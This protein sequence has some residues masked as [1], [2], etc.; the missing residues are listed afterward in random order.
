[1]T[2]S[3]DVCNAIANVV[4]NLWPDRMIYRDFCPVD[5]HRP[6]SYLYLTSSQMTP[7]NISMVQWEME[8]S[9]ELFCSTDEYDISSTEELRK[10]QEAVLLAFASPSIQVGDRW[11]T[12]TAKGDGM[13]MGSAFVAFSAA[14][15]EQRPGYHDPDDTTDPVSSAVPKMEHV[16]C[17]RTFSAQSQD[18][19]TI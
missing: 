1:M 5:H 4:A 10:D 19:R 9:L 3:I 13:D 2:T 12:L 17:S 8:A 14:W 6:S 11:V 16:E 15:T 18:E 7:V